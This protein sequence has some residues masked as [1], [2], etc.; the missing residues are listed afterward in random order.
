MPELLRAASTAYEKAVR[1]SLAGARCGDI[2]RSG[3]HVLE[4]LVYRGKP[5][6]SLTKELGISKQA[7]SQLFE[8][9]VHAGYLERAPD[10]ED[11]RRVT[12]AIT[13]LGH[14]AAIAA[15][16]GVDSVDA[17]ANKAVSAGAMRDLRAGLRAFL[18]AVT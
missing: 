1:A 14:L 12:F 5:A 2:P 4:G 8:R 15:R 3:V 13:E 16:V 9:L 6:Q 18:D 7:E 11:R 10:P 17:T